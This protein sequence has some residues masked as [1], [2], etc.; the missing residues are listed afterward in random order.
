MGC[1]SAF[2]LAFFMYTDHNALK[3]ICITVTTHI[4]AYSS[5]AYETVPIGDHATLTFWVF[6]LCPLLFMSSAAFMF[7]LYLLSSLRAGQTQTPL[8]S[9]SIRKANNR[10]TQ[11]AAS[12]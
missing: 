3:R 5:H 8:C 12:I 7:W 4:L 2:S 1:R 6:L 11:P 9:N 10:E